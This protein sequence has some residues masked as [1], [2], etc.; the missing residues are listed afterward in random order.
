MAWSALLP[1]TEANLGIFKLEIISD[2]WVSL[3]YLTILSV[4]DALA[5]SKLSQTSVETQAKETGSSKP[6]DLTNK[7]QM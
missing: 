1:G 5:D 7:E 2:F 6:G 3:I 4:D